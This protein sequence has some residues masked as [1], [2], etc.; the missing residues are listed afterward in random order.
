[1]GFA[2]LNTIA[3]FMFFTSRVVGK[4]FKIINHEEDTLFKRYPY[5]ILSNYI[6]LFI[7]LIAS[8]MY[9][10]VKKFGYHLPKSFVFPDSLIQQNVLLLLIILSFIII[11]LL[12]LGYIFFIHKR[13]NIDSTKE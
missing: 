1:M 10:Y 8:W 11:L 7:F 2:I 3:V 12:I 13:N 9:L 5:I 6:L 4:S